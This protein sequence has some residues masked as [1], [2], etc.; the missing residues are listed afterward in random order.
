MAVFR[1]EFKDSLRDRRALL[2]AMLP[3][4]FGPVLMMLLL[5]SVAETRS[6]AEDLVLPV[7]G[8]ENAPDLIAYLGE[9]GIEIEAFEGDPKTE[10]QAKNIDL[11]L[12][13]P[14]DFG[15]RFDE[16]LTAQVEIYTDG[17]LERSQRAAIRV[18]DVITTYGGNIGALRLM[19]RGVNPAVASPVR[20]QMRD[21]STRSSRAGRILGTLQMLILM[22]SFFGA[23]GAAIDTTAGE[24]ERNSLEPLLVHPVSS[25]QI[26]GGK[27][28]AVSL[29]GA[30]AIV[31]VVLSTSF[32]L[33]YF[34]LEGLGV[35]PELTVG[36]QIRIIAVLLPMALL[37]SS[38]QMLASLF[39][40][41]FKEAQTYIGMIT[42]LPI[43]PIMITTF[44]DIK[45]ADWMYTVP[46]LGQQQLITTV[47]R[48]EGMSAA[49]ALTTMAVT[50]AVALLLFAVLTRL[51][52]SERVV[53]GG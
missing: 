11:V 53:Y 43:L 49:A 17:S 22:A 30:L 26:M 27:W 21:F 9:R 38:A 44:R 10:I 8:A 16:F 12:S 33:S 32:C 19:V 29:Y 42:L 36:M 15:E 3:A 40:R 50:T 48:G 6:Q 34:S 39:A 35:D 20:V 14:E 7:I 37:A 45:T 18:S 24:R 31:L 41:T 28:I 51:L 1:K 25:S 52:R 23:A 47:M 46:I 4:I 5:S 13:I 2:T